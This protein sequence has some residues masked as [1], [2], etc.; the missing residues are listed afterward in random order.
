MLLSTITTLFSEDIMHLTLEERYYIDIES[1][2][3]TSHNEIADSGARNEFMYYASND[4]LY[5]S[6]LSQV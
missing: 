1:K 4:V 2:K 3:G 5:R 6:T